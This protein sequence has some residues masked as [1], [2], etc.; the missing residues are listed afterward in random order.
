MCVCVCVHVRV[1]ACAR[2]CLSTMLSLPCRLSKHFTFSLQCELCWPKKKI[3]H[4]TMQTNKSN[5]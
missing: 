1:R 5:E 2:L 4:F 3:K